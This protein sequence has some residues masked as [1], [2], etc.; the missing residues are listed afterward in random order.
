V[1]KAAAFEAFIALFPNSVMRIEALE[2]AM[3]AYQQAGDATRLEDTAKRICQLDAGN[4][5]ALA[6][7]TYLSRGRA[8]QGDAQAVAQTRDYAERGLRALP[9]WR[10]PDGFSASDFDRLHDQMA[11][12][13]YGAS[14]YV[15]LQAKDYA[16]AR[17]Y[18]LKSVQLD[19]SNLQDVY[20][21]SI[22]ALEMS[23]VDVNGFWYIARAAAL[24]E[25]SNNASLKQ[26]VVNFGK[27]RYS[28]YHGGDDG[29]DRLMAEAKSKT[30]PP[31]GFS[32]TAAMTSK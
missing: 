18:Y 5:R 14:G 19:P 21:L 30:P 8:T 9:E 13:F 7:V 24:A 29:W 32:V 17:G 4:V 20:Q 1:K 23:P 16:A 6:I 31:Q 25:A 26:S 22:A 2:Q 15:A 28:R 12:I 3:G 27:A 10:K 11:G